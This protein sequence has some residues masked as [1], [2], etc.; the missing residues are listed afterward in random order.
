M[1]NSLVVTVSVLCFLAIA[2]FTFPFG[3]GS[4]I[5]GSQK[6]YARYDGNYL[7]SPEWP[8]TADEMVPINPDN[9]P[10]PLFSIDRY[11]ATIAGGRAWSVPGLRPTTRLPFSEAREACRNAGKRMCTLIEWQTACRGGSTLPVSF[12]KPKKLLEICD[13]ARSGGYDATDFVN[14]NN[15]HPECTIPSLDIH[16][17]K[18][19]V[20]EFVVVPDGQFAVVGL[21]YYDQRISD[22]EYAMEYACER[23]VAQPG[24][25]PENRFNEG[26]GFRCCR[27]GG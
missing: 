27:D 19:N 3:S 22:K 17:M 13:F 2:Y 25:Y 21:T 9:S 23:V 11:E 8:K 20:S 14:K 16:H 15:S 10:V 24:Q 7:V 5:K 26:L 4:Q 1:K 18:G 6:I 12:S